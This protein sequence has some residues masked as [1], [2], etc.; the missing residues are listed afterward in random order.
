M[1]LRESKERK[2]S[3]VTER[4]NKRQREKP[5]C[6]DRLGGLNFKEIKILWENSLCSGRTSGPT[7]RKCCGPTEPQREFK[8]LV[9]IDGGGAGPNYKP[10][11]CESKGEDAIKGTNN[12][13]EQL[14]SS[15]HVTD[16]ESWECLSGGLAAFSALPPWAYLIWPYSHYITPHISQR[17]S[18]I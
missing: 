18:I 3:R 13:S 1:C 8:S 2:R 9:Q 14:N 17:L 4:E 7:Q 16:E 5:G 12:I 11:P 6:Y 10:G 15:L